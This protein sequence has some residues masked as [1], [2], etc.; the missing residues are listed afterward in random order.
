MSSQHLSRK[1]RFL[2]ELSTLAFITRGGNWLF[3][4]LSRLA[5]PLM[6]LSTLYVIAE[7]VL[8]AMFKVSSLVHLSSVSIIILNT[9]PEVILPGC[10]MQ[11]RMAEEN[12]RW[13][14]KSMGV[15][16]ILL[17][18]VTLASFIWSFSAGVVAVIL[19]F[20]CAAGVLYSLLVR[21]SPQPFMQIPRLQQAQLEELAEGLQ[22]SFNQQVQHLTNELATVEESLHA[23]LNESST[24]QTDLTLHLAKELAAMKENVQAE[25]AILPTLQAQQYNLQGELQA[26]LRHMASSTSEELQKVRTS[27]EKQEC[28]Q[29]EAPQG[30]I[31]R[32]A[33]RALPSVQG[34]SNEVRARHVKETR[35]FVLEA[36][37]EEKRDARAFIFACLEKQAALKLSEIKHLARAEGQELSEATISRYRKQFFASRESSR[38]VDDESATLKAESANESERGQGKKPARLSP[39]RKE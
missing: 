17:T 3:L 6:F 22:K 24:T 26:Q 13:M 27:L 4:L 34:N 39:S 31:E 23:R 37:R 29:R 33:L 21:I 7:T 11:A 2:H 38:G 5:G 16:F 19:F 10:F 15:L 8:P 14:Y 20:R 25:L 36:A 12:Q 30:P 1:E 35:Q 32:P 18:F 9:A 28:E